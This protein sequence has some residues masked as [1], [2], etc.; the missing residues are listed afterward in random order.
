MLNSYPPFVH[1]GQFIFSL[2]LFLSLSV[3]MPV[4]VHGDAIKA[5]RVGIIDNKPMCYIDDTGK[6]AGIFVEIIEHVA[7]REGWSL[8]YV[9]GTWANLRAG[10]SSGEIDILLSMAYSAERA[11]Q[12]SFN[13]IAVFNNW[14]EVY[15]FSGSSIYSLLDLK[16][17]RIASLAKGIYTTGPEGIV[18]LN[19]KFNL[20][21]ELV[22]T[23]SYLEAMQ[24]VQEGKA[25]A[26][27]VNRLTGALYSES[28]GFEK[29]GIV[30]APVKIHFA[31]NRDNP[32][33][34]EIIEKLDKTLLELK[35]DPGSRYH[36]S[37]NLALGGE[38]VREVAPLW[39]LWSL[40][41]LLLLFFFIVGFNFFL[42][43]QVN[44]KTLDLQEVNVK[45]KTDMER[46]VKIEADLRESQERFQALAANSSDW[47]WEIDENDSYTYGSPRITDLLGYAPDEIVGKTPFDFMSAPNRIKIADAFQVLK[48]ARQP[49][50][51]LENVN[52]HKDGSLVVLES[53]GV[54]AFDKDGKYQG[55]RGIDRDISKRKKIEAQLQQAQKLEAIGTLAGGVAH[56][57]NNL[58]TPILGYSEML[59]TRFADESS[60]AGSLGEV[61]N[62][63]N[64]AKDL[65]N[66]I[67]TL[68]RQTEHELI[69]VKMH[70]ILKEALKLLRST[71]PKSIDIQE[72]ITASG[73]VLADPTQM[74][75]IIM[76]LGTN[77]YHAMREDGGVLSVSLS[78][79]DISREDQ[80]VGSLDLIP[81]AYL[82]LAFSDTGHG[83]D[84][85][86]VKR[87]F[88]PY[89]TTKKIGEG[90][91]LGLAV[92]H[93][94]VKSHNGHI[95]VYSEV[96]RGTQFNVYLPYSEPTGTDQKESLGSQQIP[97]GHE[98]VLLVDDEES[99]VRMETQLL[100]GLGYQVT[101]ATSPT[102]LR[103][104][105]I[106]NP[107]DF[108]LIITD[109]S[110]PE[111]NGA[112]LAKDI[113]SIRP[114]LPIILCTG[115]SDTIDEKKAKSIGIK[116]FL[117]KPIVLQNLAIKVRTIL[118]A[119]G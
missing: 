21:I 63:A 10:L 6:P 27:V 66:Q 118:D 97:G 91:G 108:D 33:T 11:E 114:D 50:S 104:I 55:Y 105:F 116:S 54:P 100:R 89:F 113:L 117:I 1:Q 52:Q 68:S 9:H 47:I 57:F 26:A 84:Q 103:D 59:R 30:F 101:A 56:D 60:E 94:I 15:V 40:G 112:D 74:H 71:I 92:V 53:S 12:Y 102:R 37:I 72:N 38:N 29:S 98:H 16:K 83:M 90:T 106:D 85:A 87:V 46:R 49:F 31:L 86:T 81:G 65:V 111:I 61:I 79:V 119:K 115:F 24:A 64:R 2:S 107:E 25:E 39:V 35:K 20:E 18:N 43:W 96:D 36:Q 41:I 44:K 77:A 42:R 19:E 32:D 48:A 80:A 75:Q 13:K 99:I 76:N 110:M 51:N 17:K 7:D 3:L 109:M 22:R 28:M 14:A 88:E 70:L 95:S 93:G 69:S 5:I 82:K 34:P 73:S 8:E 45:L 67:L 4:V 78:S 23:S 62:A 58:L